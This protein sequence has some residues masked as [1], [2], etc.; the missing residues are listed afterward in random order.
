MPY[1]THRAGTSTRRIAKQRR[2][3]ALFRGIIGLAFLLLLTLLLLKP[4]SLGIGTIGI[5]LLLLLALTLPNLINRGVDKKL[6]EEK[7]AVRGAKGE[8]KI[9]DILDQLSEDYFVLNDIESPFG[10]IDHI[11]I[12]RQKGIFLIETKAHGGRVEM[13]R[14]RLLVNGR[15]PEKDFIGQA[16]KNT[17][18]LRDEISKTIGYKP[19][20]T[21]VI[22]FTNAF[23]AE[24]RSKGVRIVNQK[25]LVHV[26]FAGRANAT[27]QRAWEQ[28]E[29]IREG[30]Y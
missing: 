20:I 2:N 9:G 23:V 8:E 11:V 30:L 6:K 16:L 29:L 24:G 12:G 18:W 3:S 5:T 22:V 1:S 7:R 19:W 10:N 15:L 21:P 27:E 14:D 17:Y 13:D 25:Y 28:R 4:Q 26:L